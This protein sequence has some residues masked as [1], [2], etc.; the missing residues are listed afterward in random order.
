MNA[1]NGAPGTVKRLAGTDIYAIGVTLW[2][3]IFPSVGLDVPC[4]RWEH[5][6]VPQDEDYILLNDTV[7]PGGA[8]QPYS[9]ELY[10]L[11][12]LC[13]QYNADSRPDLVTLNS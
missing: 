8:I 10:D 1:R 13:V 4:L 6:F 12:S 9:Q 3:L 2:S 7:P 5:P 11:V